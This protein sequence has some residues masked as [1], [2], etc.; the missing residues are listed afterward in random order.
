MFA[1]V[2]PTLNE[3]GNL[4]PLALA[5]SAVLEGITWELV[6]VDDDSPDRTWEEAALL[7]REGLPVR[8]VRRVGR[9]G[10]ASAVIEG[11]LACD[12]DLIAVIDADGQHDERL[13]PAMRRLLASGDAELVIGSRYVDGGG[14][15]DWT[16]GR[17]LMSDFA[18]RC[19][20]LLIGRTIT[21]PMS[22]FFAFRRAVLDAALYDLSQQGFKIL[23]DLVASSPRPL[24]IVE[25]PYVF[26]PRR[27]GASKL[28]LS[29]LAE[30]LFLLVEKATRGSVPPRFVLYALVGGV[31]LLPHLAVLVL[32][33]AAHFR[34]LPAQTIATGVAMSVNYVVNNAFTYRSQRL[35]GAAFARGY[36]IY[37]AICSI[38][39]LAN[40]GV[41][42]LA[43]GTWRSWSLAG[44]AGA[45]I[46]SVFNFGVATQL[47]WRSRRRPVV[48]G[49]A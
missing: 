27:A 48:T 10:L 23:L 31:G 5:I 6:V 9:R 17:R 12:A 47:V 14:T 32:L 49:A 29:T 37:G 24:R 16:A 18:T 15:G 36:V 8:C 1:V 39:A 34:F 19:A 30:F 38:G 41:A 20:A 28:D 46:G 21:D 2:T 45:L 13:L 11:A 35:R 43:I 26:R 42:N 22:G 40:I 3:R 25:L 44:I 4:R 33:G 7:A